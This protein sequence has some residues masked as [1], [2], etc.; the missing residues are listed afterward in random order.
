MPRT[1]LGKKNIINPVK[2]RQTLTRLIRVAM[3]RKDIRSNS[4]A[5]VLLAMDDSCFGKRMNGVNHWTFE[6]LCRVFRTL[7]FTPEEV[8][9]AMGVTDT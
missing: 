7:E 4:K 2:Q 5:A 6:D 9:Q 8:L 1:N 3:A